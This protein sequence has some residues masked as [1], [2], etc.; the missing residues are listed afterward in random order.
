MQETEIIDRIV[1]LC[2]IRGWSF[3][4]LSKESG[5]PYST[6]CTMLHKANAPSIPTLYKLCKGFGISLSEFFDTEGDWA[7]LTEEEKKHLE[8]WNTLTP[9]N[10]L[11]VDTYI[12][13]VIKQ[14]S[15]H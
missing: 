7:T 1:Q 15:G 14:Q 5:I 8:R 3:Y 9:D 4:R 2:S 6:L 13:F 11:S 12:E 10:R